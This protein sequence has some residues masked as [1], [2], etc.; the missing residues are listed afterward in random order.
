M[1]DY[2]TLPPLPSGLDYSDVSA[3][4]LWAIRSAVHLAIQKRLGLTFDQ[5]DVSYH[6]NFT[7][8][9]IMAED[10]KEILRR[11]V[12]RA[13]YPRDEKDEHLSFISHSEATM[14]RAIVEGRVNLD[15]ENSFIFVSCGKTAVEL[16]GYELA[17][18]SPLAIS[19][20]TAGSIHA[21]G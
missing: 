18:T 21:C 3:D 15:P 1:V 19:K 13:G 9:D 11:V 17:Q 12:A 2:T 4:F 8:P 20:L 16:S 10:N 5:D 14:H 6:W 7:V